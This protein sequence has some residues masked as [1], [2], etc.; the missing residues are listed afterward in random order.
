MNALRRTGLLAGL[1][2]GLASGA[3]AFAAADDPAPAMGRTPDPYLGSWVLSIDGAPAG[4]VTTVEGCNV[5]GRVLTH[6]GPSGASKTLGVVTPARCSFEFGQDMSPQLYAWIS[7]ELARTGSPRK[8]ELARVDGKAT[9]YAFELTGTRLS[10]LT[11]PKVQRT[12]GA[13]VLLKATVAPE[14]I[15]RIKPLG[16]R[17]AQSAV[18][19]FAPS[20]VAATLGATPLGV[21]TIGPFT[22]SVQMAEPLGERRQPASIPGQVELSNL[23]LRAPD[24]SAATQ[25]DPWLHSFVVDGHSTDADERALTISLG[26]G[27]KTKGVDI[28]MPK[29]GFV[30]GDLAARGDGNRGY[31]LYTESVSVAVR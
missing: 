4:A 29:T 5:G 28:V 6:A 2:T 27:A 26:G 25:L 10:E 23:P 12:S 18:I 22:A 21:D 11:L 30:A 14:R 13:A 31:E 3:A 16:A 15:R 7:D 20:Q 17:A 1:T 24:V 19:G 8:L 9:L